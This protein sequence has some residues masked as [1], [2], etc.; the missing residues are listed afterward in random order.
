[1]LPNDL[2]GDE[3]ASKCYVNIDKARHML[4]YEP[5]LN[6]ARGM[7]LTADYLRQAYGV[8]APLTRRARMPLRL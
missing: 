7:D 3:S 2:H 1:M 5:A 6:F 8:V 4:G